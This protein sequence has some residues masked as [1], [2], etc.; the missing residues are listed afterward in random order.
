[1]KM[2][3]STGA[4]G[5]IHYINTLCMQGYTFVLQE[6]IYGPSTKSLRLQRS[7]FYRGKVWTKMALLFATMMRASLETEFL[8]PS[9]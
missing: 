2:R 1:M 9:L 6:G 3:C 8:E 4:H 7:L 5:H